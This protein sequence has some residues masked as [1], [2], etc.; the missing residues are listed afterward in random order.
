MK[1]GLCTVVIIAAMAGGRL[2]AHHSYA[3]YETDRMGESEGVS[4]EFAVMSP[5][6][7]LKVRGAD[8]RLYTAE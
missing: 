4:D 7:L 2:S 3:A 6:S 5:H 8:G 1:R